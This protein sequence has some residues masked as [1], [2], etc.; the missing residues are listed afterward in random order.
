[1]ARRPLCHPHRV[2]AAY[3]VLFVADPAEDRHA[4]ALRAVAREVA[5]A[6]FFDDPEAEAA[7]TVGTYLCVDTLAEPAAQGLVARVAAVSERFSLRVEVQLREEILG[8]IRDGRPDAAL[9]AALA[10][11]S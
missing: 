10:T 8:H 11:A 5:G 7:R 1:M 3:L 6:G 4:E 2:S 9:A